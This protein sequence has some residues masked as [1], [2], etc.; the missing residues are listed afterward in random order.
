MRLD[1]IDELVPEFVE[2]SREHLDRFEQDVMG[3]EAEPASAELA[4]SA[5]RALH[6]LKG[7][8]SYFGFATVERVAH[9]GESVLVSIREGRVA[10]A[11]ATATA[12]LDVA[13]VLRSLLDGIVEDGQEPSLD[14]GVVETRLRRCLDEP[15]TP[16]TP[17]RQRFGETLVAAGAVSPGNVAW[18]VSQQVAGDARPIGAILLEAGLVDES[19]IES[20]LTLQGRSGHET[21]VRVG[22]EVLDELV[23]L[24]GELTR[25]RDEIVPLL[26]E[27]A[28]ARLDR[29]AHG[30]RAAVMRTRVEP[31]ERSWAVL[32]RLVRDLA[33]DCGKDVR[34]VTD[35]AA[36]SVDRTLLAAVKDPVLHLV[37]NAVDHG[38]EPRLERRAAGKPPTAT[39]TLRAYADEHE[40]V[41]E[42]TDDGRGIDRR[43]VRAV[44]VERGI[45]TPSQTAAM[46][47]SDI[48][49]LVLRPGFSTATTVTNLSG[50]G[51]GLD[52]VRSDVERVGG[53]V[54]V[55]SREG[56]GCTWRLRL[57][58]SVGGRPAETPPGE[59]FAP[60]GS[61]T[62]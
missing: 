22:L 47:E 33:H 19:Q 2:E 6:T 4:N 12:L 59:P 40:V 48:D 29:V 56:L 20:V 51:V 10:F 5:F 39:L 32:P 9:L 13:D 30:L 43:R 61:G 50:R 23:Q 18:A 3:L 25:T 14:T 31:I 21:S 28:R 35:G 38:I 58:A 45:V 8:S 55:H 34:L 11:P 27:P 46:T 37:R 41:L 26:P 60:S 15:P 7:T 1:E 49:A 42:V 16:A 17:P 44:A 53:R 62:V 24:V 52:V 54:E 36:T 57:P